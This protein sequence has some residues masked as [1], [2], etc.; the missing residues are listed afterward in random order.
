M[1]HPH[2]KRDLCA[3]EANHSGLQIVGAYFLIVII[4]HKSWASGDCVGRKPHI[5]LGPW[6]A[7]HRVLRA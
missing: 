2:D 6:V 7:L 4:L 5:A 1:V 3:T